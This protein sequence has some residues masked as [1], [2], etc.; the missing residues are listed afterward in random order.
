MAGCKD[1]QL[2]A[3]IRTA[4]QNNYNVRIAAT[5]I[6]QAEAQLGITKSNE[7]P[8]AVGV[9]AALLFLYCIGAVLGPLIASTLMSFAGPA[10]L[11]GH[12]AVVHIALIAF[13]LR[14]MLH[15]PAPVLR[16]AEGRMPQL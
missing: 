6:L 2:Q 12:T 4:V 11:Y 9:A 13:T 5:R 15:R 1:P 7:Y 10:A 14:Q 3:L 8:S 16:S